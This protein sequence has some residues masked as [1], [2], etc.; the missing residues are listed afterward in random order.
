[1][2]VINIGKRKQ[3]E[4]ILNDREVVMSLAV[5]NIQDFQDKHGSLTKALDEMKKENIEVILHLIYS[6]LSDKKTGKILGKKYVEQFDELELL[7][8]LTPLVHQIVGTELPT[9]KTETEKK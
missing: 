6:M 3:E 7:N 4:F 2:D 5:K 8:S 9:A 1:M